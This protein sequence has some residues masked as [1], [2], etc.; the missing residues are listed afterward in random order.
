MEETAIGVEAAPPEKKRRKKAT[1]EGVVT[2]KKARAKKTEEAKPVPTDLALLDSC[3]Q[4]PAL[5][6]ERMNGSVNPVRIMGPKTARVILVADNPQ[7]GEAFHGAPDWERDDWQVVVDALSSAEFTFEE[8]AVAYATRCAVGRVGDKAKLLKSEVISNCRPW[9]HLEL[10]EYPN[11]Q[12]IMCLGRVATSAVLGC[13]LLNYAKSRGKIHE[14]SLAGR[15]IRVVVSSHPFQVLSSPFEK[16]AFEMDFRQ[17]RAAAEPDYAPFDMAR[18]QETHTEKYHLVDSVG[19]LQAMVDR[20]LEVPMVAFDTETRGLDPFHLPTPDPADAGLPLKF[21]TTIQFSPTVGESYFVPVCHKDFNI[22]TGAELT[23][24]LETLRFFFE[25]YRGTL[26]GFNGKFDQVAILHDL[27]VL[28]RL[29]MDPMIVD[30]LRRGMPARSLKKLAW[31]VSSYGGY[32]TQLK[33]SAPA[34]H[35]HDSYYYPLEELFWYGCLD[36]DVTYRAA[37][38]FAPILAADGKLKTLSDF[39]AAASGVLAEVAVDGWRIDLKYL[40]EYGATQLKN[41]AGAKAAIR[42]VAAEAVAA[43]E[44]QYGKEFDPSSSKSLSFLLFDLLGL[45]SVEKTDK[46]AP[47]T[48]KG[49]LSAIETHHP[50]VPLI[51]NMR[52]ADKAYSAFYKRWK[53]GVGP[54]GRLH[55][56]YNL[57]KFRDLESGEKGGTE[58]MPAGELVLTD[59]GYLPVEQ[60]RVG[61]F[62]ISHKGSPSRVEAVVDNGE[63]EVVE[64]TTQEGHSLLTTKN[65]P[66]HV[67]YDDDWLP[68]AKLTEGLWVTVHSAPERWAKIAGFEEFSVSSWGRVRND[69][70]GRQ[71]TLRAKDEWGHLKVCLYRNGAQQ[72]GPD[73][74]DFPVHRLVA[75][76]FI[77]LPSGS[78]TEVRHLDGIAWNN[79]VENLCWGTRKENGEDS[80]QHGTM[81]KRGTRS[82]L[83]EAEAILI[84]DTP[85]SVKSDRVLAEELGVCRRLIGDIRNGKRWT[86]VPEPLPYPKFRCSAIAAVTP[87][88]RMKTYG[89]TV[90]GTHSHVTGGFLTHNT[91]RLSSSGA[92]GNAQQITKDPVIRKTFLPD[93]P[94]DVLV[95]IDFS[96]LEYVIAAVYSKDEKLCAAFKKGYDIHA[97]VAAEM[98]DSTPEEMSKPENKKLRSKGKTMNFCVPM[99]TQALTRD[100]WK[101][102]ANL[103]VGERVLAYDKATG[104]CR[105]TPLRRVNLFGESNLVEVGNEHFKAVATPNHRWVSRR[106]T[107]RGKTRRYVDEMVESVGITS[108]HEVVR[109]AKA[110][111]GLGLPITSQ[112]AAIV[113]WLFTDGHV[114][115][116][117]ATGAKQQAGGKKVSLQASIFQKKLR[118]VEDIRLLLDTA[119]V[120]YSE[121]I[122]PTGIHQFSLRPDYAR[123]LFHRIGMVSRDFDWEHFVLTLS[124]GQRVAFL[125][126][127]WRAEGHT[128]KGVRHVSQNRGRLLDAVQLAIFL[129][130]HYPSMQGNARCRQVAYGKPTFTGQRVKVRGVPPAEVWC[131]TT[132]LG[133]WVARQGDRMFITGNSALYGAGPENVADQLKCSK[134]EA[135]EFLENYYA[136]FPGLVKWIAATKRA[137]RK[138]GRATSKMGRFRALPDAM[139]PDTKANKGRIEAALRQAVN[140]PIQGDASDVCLWGLVR[141]ADLIRELKLQ[142][143][144]KATIH[145]A[146]ILSC[147]PE[148]VFEVIDAVCHILTNPGL[149]WLDGPKGPGVP[150]RVSVEIG[151]TWGDMVSYEED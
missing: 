87:V 6:M 141:V 1:P 130:G 126:A 73:R 145:D 2:P 19:E 95:D 53:E 114:R 110:E 127:F 107:G 70:T 57:I 98:F 149:E 60:V 42:S 66:F 41:V 52:K 37:E 150:L 47:S 146:I 133:T 97:A 113:A 64:V 71:A 55:F 90:G 79:T 33:S 38:K 12:A 139:L 85:R 4:C 121:Y 49:A 115:F 116:G 135:E 35:E 65:H 143:R 34:G 78:G 120:T 22:W 11:V 69:K 134:E 18:H 96:T 62:V 106:R 88:G 5:V 124:A 136:K 122:R 103:S 46:G 109:A 39:L 58:C 82:K 63:A 23:Q 144:I 51:L 68:A 29:S 43:F 56:H 3:E 72:R 59:R 67:S 16:E 20:L 104:T 30:Q 32:E 54:D 140:G 100:G 93:R 81:R 151:E 15:S 128:R 10:A 77:P 36:T 147:P 132:D 94:G 111:G 123:D 119:E 105:W 13:S 92:A 101:G 117:N 26:V 21:L 118:Y 28:P 14:V 91:G 76:A 86:P 89:L 50:V 129:E 25:N 137:V 108:E 148:E 9:F 31:L 17:L 61:D 45:P 80:V 74:R 84:R 8:V 125:D 138:S 24:W 44:K 27:G 102:P 7:I 83:T 112:E 48:A 40:E 131:P 142:T 75:Q 99:D